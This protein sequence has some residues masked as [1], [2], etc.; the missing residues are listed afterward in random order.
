MVK[1]PT[2]VDVVSSIVERSEKLSE[3][4]SKIKEFRD[5]QANLGL[6]LSQAQDVLSVS[7]N[8]DIGPEAQLVGKHAE[9]IKL[10]NEVNEVNQKIYE[11]YKQAK[12][13]MLK[14]QKQKEPITITSPNYLKIKR[15]KIFF[16]VTKDSPGYSLNILL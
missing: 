3:L 10:Q 6:T 13:K 16:L 8:N 14:L 5:L 7:K 15:Y 12:E 9:L 1:L 11:A 4:E 2:N